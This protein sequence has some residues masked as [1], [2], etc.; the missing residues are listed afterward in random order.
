MKVV[1][2]MAYARYKFDSE[3]TEQDV[4]AAAEAHA[5]RRID[6]TLGANGCLHQD[7]PLGDYQV[8]DRLLKA[9]EPRGEPRRV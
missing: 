7:C 6:L 3:T 5:H 8:T 2:S 9:D 1:R 4:L